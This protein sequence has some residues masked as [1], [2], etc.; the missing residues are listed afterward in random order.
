M[1]AL[2][3]P[4]ILETALSPLCTSLSFGFIISFPMYRPQPVHVIYSAAFPLTSISPAHPLS[5]FSCRA[6]VSGCDFPYS[7]CAVPFAHGLRPHCGPRR[8]HHHFHDPAR[9]VRVR[10]RA[11]RRARLRHVKASNC[12]SVRPTMEPQT[13]AETVGSRGIRASAAPFLSALAVIVGGSDHSRT[14]QMAR[15]Y[16][17]DARA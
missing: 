6:L 8:L 7:P 4:H 3:G 10:A 12:G 1:H 16:A 9:L 11:H 14:M 17:R 15:M 5:A 13:V 2:H